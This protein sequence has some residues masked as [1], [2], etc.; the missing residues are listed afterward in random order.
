M[1]EQT[2]GKN[3]TPVNNVKYHTII[4]NLDQ[5]IANYLSTFATLYKS[6]IF[7]V[8]GNSLNLKKHILNYKLKRGIQMKQ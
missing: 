5:R 3:G 8:V 7:R 2:L 6:S 1:V 4:S